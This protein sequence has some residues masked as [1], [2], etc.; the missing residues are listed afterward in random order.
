M[1]LSDRIRAARRMK[2]WSQSKLAAE[3]KV[4]RSAVGHWERGDGSAPSA[5]RLFAL[6]RITGV[7]VEWIANGTGPMLIAPLPEGA[8]NAPRALSNEEE[9][10]LS[11][12]SRISG[13]ARLLLLELAETQ[14]STPDKRPRGLIRA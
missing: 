1:R 10:L 9:H 12:F 2:G 6:S 3:L 5:A 14:A 8:I 13:R 11:C 4:D 7:C